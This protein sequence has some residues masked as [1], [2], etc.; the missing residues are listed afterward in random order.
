[1]PLVPIPYLSLIPLIGLAA[2][3]VLR[4]GWRNLQGYALAIAIA[5]ALCCAVYLVA[6]SY[7]DRP[8]I[9]GSS[10]L[11]QWVRDVYPPT[12]RMTTFPARTPAWPP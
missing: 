12:G 1:M 4:G 6:Q 9:V 5:L 2:F 11:D 8:V 7:V 3:V 10:V